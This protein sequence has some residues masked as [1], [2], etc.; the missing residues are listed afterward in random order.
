M[1]QYADTY[2]RELSVGQQQRVCIAKALI[3][4]ADIILMDEPF[5]GQDAP[6][7]EELCNILKD[8]IQLI[9]NYLTLL[10]LHRNKLKCMQD[11]HYHY[12]NR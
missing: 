3:K 1:D 4:E 12:V 6:L 7:R 9:S 8:F 11:V 10:H 2:P 5:S